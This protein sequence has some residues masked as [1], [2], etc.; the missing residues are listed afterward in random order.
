MQQLVQFNQLYQV[1]SDE[2]SLL[3][4]IPQNSVKITLFAELELVRQVTAFTSLEK[5]L[6]SSPVFRLVKRDNT[7]FW[8]IFS[9][10]SDVNDICQK[11]KDSEFDFICWPQGV[12]KPPKLILFDMD[13][14][15]I[16]IEVIDQ[17]AARHN[18]G[19]K[20]AKVTEAAMQGK[21]DFAESLVSRV[22]CLQGL[23]EAAIDDIAQSLPLSP[24]IPQL[25]EAAAKNNCYI[26]IVSGGFTPFVEKL[27][28]ELSLYKVKANV[29]EIESGQLTGKV[30]GSI[31]DAKAKAEFLSSLCEELEL[32]NSEVMAIGDGANDLLM[33]NE[34]G[35][36][37]AYHAKPTVQAQAKGRIEHTSFSLLPV[38][39]G[40][41]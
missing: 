36:N 11:T 24:G 34:A 5:S 16:Q 23:N 21:L 25:V 33:M 22:A 2:W 32:A 35:F 18:V 31:V 20:V 29:L 39:F 15:F 8:E 9:E 13:S 14:T 40:W 4:E 12:D 6:V 26:A 7:F 17:L 10:S 3:S 28:K 38:V 37:L 27:K 19:E 30:L 41:S 1:H